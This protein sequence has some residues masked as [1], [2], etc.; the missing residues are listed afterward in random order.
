MVGRVEPSILF[1]IRNQWWIY[2]LGGLAS[3]LIGLKL[4]GGFYNS[5]IIWHSGRKEKE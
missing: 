5:I 3:G 4:T 1:D 2:Y